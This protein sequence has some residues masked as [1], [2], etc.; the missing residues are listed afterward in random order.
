MGSIPLEATDILDFTPDSLANIVP[1]PVFR[2]KAGSRREREKYQHLV[3]SEGLRYHTQ[4]SLRA[5][6]LRGLQELW[7][8]DVFAE[9]QGRL[10]AFWDA[11]EQHHK[12]I[13]G[14]EDP[15]A[16][17]HPD[18][19]AVQALT[20]EVTRAWPPLR[21]MGADNLTFTNN[22]PALMLSI[23]LKGWSNFD[24]SF[25]MHGGVIPLD[26]IE[27]LEEA[28]QSAEQKA[29]AEKID[30][31]GQP[32]T[33]FLQLCAAAGKRLWLSRSEEKN[34]S[35][36]APSAP[37]QPPSETGGEEIA[38]TSKAQASSNETPAG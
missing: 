10:K 14:V 34:S 21:T 33:A 2:L 15:P 4:E 6:T 27:E 25:G 20:D 32:G 13:E 24:C 29:S 18:M 26:K 5:E 9:Q 19:A 28:L 12:A 22:S 1:K 11:V 31:V 8:P 36:P 23:I 37:T 35:S 7:S 38:G 3:V 30:G 16:F 17:E